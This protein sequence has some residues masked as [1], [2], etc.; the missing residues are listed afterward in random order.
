MAPPL[1]WLRYTSGWANAEGAAEGAAEGEGPDD[2]YVALLSL[3]DRSGRRPLGGRKW[4]QRANPT[5]S[6]DARAQI[7]GAEG[8]PAQELEVVEAMR[9]RLCAAAPGFTVAPAIPRDW[10]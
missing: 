9:F 6:A 5:V 2:R 10:A 3:Y 4:G 8:I 7:G 1:L